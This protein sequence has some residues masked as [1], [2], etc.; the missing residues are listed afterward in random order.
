LRRKQLSASLAG[1]L[2]P[3]DVTEL[4]ALFCKIVFLKL[5]YFLKSKFTSKV[6]LQAFKFNKEAIK[7]FITF[8][9]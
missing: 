4:K 2:N 9:P 1:K 8:K 6:F 7:E 5:F 3:Q